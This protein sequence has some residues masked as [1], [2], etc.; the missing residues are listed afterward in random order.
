MEMTMRRMKQLALTFMLVLAMT[1]PPMTEGKAATT[2]SVKKI[3]VENC[4]RIREFY[5]GVAVVCELGDDFKYGL[6][7]K[8]GKKIIMG[9]YDDIKK[10]F[11]WHG[12]GKEERQIW[13]Y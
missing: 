10:F 3:E 7:D 6:I 11:R 5:N 4:H 8:N 13:L 9:K 2:G 12:I 1:I